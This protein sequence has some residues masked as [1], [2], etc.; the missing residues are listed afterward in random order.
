LRL[1][2][3]LLVDFFI[4]VL[5]LVLTA[6]DNEEILNRLKRFEHQRIE[7]NF[8]FHKCFEEVGHAGAEIASERDLLICISLSVHAGSVEFAIVFHGW[9]YLSRRSQGRSGP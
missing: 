7:R 1:T 5:D 4:D 8:L 3:D 2:I 9:P 6:G